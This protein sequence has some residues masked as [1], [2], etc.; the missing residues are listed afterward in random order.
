[1]KKEI[2]M[3]LRDVTN[4][5]YLRGAKIAMCLSQFTAVNVKK[6]TPAQSQAHVENNACATHEYFPSIS[7][8]L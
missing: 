4:V 6:D 1:M 7:P 8:V 3:T 5:L 2:I